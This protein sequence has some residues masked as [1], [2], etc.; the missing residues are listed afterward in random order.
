MLRRL[1]RVGC[2]T[3]GV[4]KTV[5]LV[6]IL[7]HLTAMIGLPL[8]DTLVAATDFGIR[9]WC[10]AWKPPANPTQAK[11]SSRRR[12]LRLYTYSIGQGALYAAGADS[13][14]S[15]RIERNIQERRDLVDLERTVLD[16]AVTLHA[17]RSDQIGYTPLLAII[18]VN[19]GLL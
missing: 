13:V 2:S 12:Q 10:W 8:R 9:A 4:A 1:G 18:S 19:Y 15:P 17:I 7:A 16:P 6:A 11:S 3:A 5:A 14:F